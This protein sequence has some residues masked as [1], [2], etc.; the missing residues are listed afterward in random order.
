MQIIKEKKKSHMTSSCFDSLSVWCPV[1]TW[2]RSGSV[3][4]YVVWY[5]CLY[6]IVCRTVHFNYTRNHTHQISTD[7]DHIHINYSLKGRFCHSGFGH[8]IYERA[9]TMIYSVFSSLCQ[10]AYQP[11]L[12]HYF[13]AI[14]LQRH[15]K[16]VANLPS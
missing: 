2:R 13:D 7:C 12:Y 15:L 3:L 1:F 11:G 10:W 16:S 6:R 5:D 8:C 4:F 9:Q 14:T